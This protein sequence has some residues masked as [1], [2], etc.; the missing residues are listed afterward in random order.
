MI[1]FI[2]EKGM[3]DPIG[4][5]L[6]AKVAVTAF[7]AHTFAELV[8]RTGA[9][10][11]KDVYGCVDVEMYM[12]ET[13]GKKVLVYKSPVGAPAAVSAMEEVMACGVEHVVA[14]GICGA[15][16]DVPAHTFVVPNRAFRDEGTSLH[17]APAS[18]FAEVKN[19]KVVEKRLAEC[20]VNTVTG[21]TWTTDGFYRETKSRAETM[22]KNGCVAVDMECSALQIAA[23]FRGKQFYTFF[24]TADSLAGEEWEPND[25]LELKVTDS[26]T[27]AATAAMTMAI[28]IAEKA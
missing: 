4:E 11:I 15:L 1:E 17:Y 3:I 28:R 5:P 9:K 25:I 18:E 13:N 22:R 19:S 2:D 14:F 10:R 24:I 16:T 21:G 6:G 8:A 26:T 27:V 20:G 12:F 7:S 23:D